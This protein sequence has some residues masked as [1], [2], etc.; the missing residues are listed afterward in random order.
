[1]FSR[2]LFGEAKSDHV[3]HDH[4][5]AGLHERWDDF[6]LQKPPGRIAVQQN[7]RIA[8]AFVDVVHAPAVDARGVWRIRPLLSD[9]GR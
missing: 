7:D 9:R 4:A 1:V 5:I 3:G 6:T 8:A 2:R